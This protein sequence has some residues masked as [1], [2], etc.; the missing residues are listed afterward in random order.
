MHRRYPGRFG[1]C[2]CRSPGRLDEAEKRLSDYALKFGEL[3]KRTAESDELCQLA[4]REAQRR[5]QEVE[6]GLKVLDRRESSSWE[7]FALERR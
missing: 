6:A 5:C 7:Q 4:R 2:C 1:L 3:D